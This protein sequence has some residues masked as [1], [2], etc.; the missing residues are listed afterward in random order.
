[1]YQNTVSDSCVENVT[2]QRVYL[3]FIW[4]T[5]RVI[6]FFA[7]KNSERHV[8]GV[9]MLLWIQ[10]RSSTAT[11]IQRLLIGHYTI[12]T[13]ISVSFCLKAI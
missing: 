11:H 10:G 5:M 3:L 2:G 4:S 12:Y 13:V 9:L 8:Y 7:L 6:W 1:M